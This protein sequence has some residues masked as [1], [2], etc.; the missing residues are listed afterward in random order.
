MS[1]SPPFFSD[2]SRAGTELVLETESYIEQVLVYVCLITAMF[3]NFFKRQ[4]HK[5]VKHTQT[6]RLTHFWCWQLKG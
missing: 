4:P 1:N 5:M 2:L 3:N 6:A